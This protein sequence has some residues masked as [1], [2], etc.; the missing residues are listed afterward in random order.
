MTADLRPV[1]V[2]DWRGPVVDYRSPGYWAAMRKAEPPTW[3]ERDPIPEVLDT[4][5]RPVDAPAEP[6]AVLDLVKRATAAG[7]LVR[8]GF[9]RGPARAV[10]VNTYKLVE[11]FGV[12]AAAH[13]DTGWRFCAMYERSIGAATGWKWDRTGIWKPGQ[14]VAPGLGPRFGHATVTDLKE[15]LEARGAVPPAWFKGV[16]ARVMSQAAK[17]KTAAKA[18][19]ATAKKKEGAS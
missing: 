19:P 7:W 14:V 8:V 11:T 3:P 1:I 2:R 15:F 10:T 9:S 18:R 13:P 16:H 6:R 12:W 4:D 5:P 17:T